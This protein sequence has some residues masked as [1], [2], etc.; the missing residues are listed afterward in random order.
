[1]VLMLEWLED[2]YLSN[3]NGDWEHSSGIKIATLDNPGWSIDINLTDTSME[4]VGFTTLKI[5]RT[6]NDWVDCFIKDYNFFARG[7][8]QN[9]NE[10]L[11][12]F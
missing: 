11:R 5:D 6:G 1:M 3:C 10:M 12:I 9:L 2:W 7:G 8:P 4:K